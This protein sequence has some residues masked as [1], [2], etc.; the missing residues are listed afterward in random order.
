MFRV[1]MEVVSLFIEPTAHI[2][3]LE[4]N[5]EI[6]GR[7]PLVLFALSLTV[8]ALVISTST[9][10]AIFVHYFSTCFLSRSL[11]I[12]SFLNACIFHR[13]AVYATWQ[14]ISILL[15]LSCWYTRTSVLAA[16][17]SCIMPPIQRKQRWCWAG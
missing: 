14:S 3:S 10:N 16:K 1:S 2:D 6:Y 17:L 5:I 8:N 11:G 7:L 13:D 4:Q 12:I 15:V 9:A